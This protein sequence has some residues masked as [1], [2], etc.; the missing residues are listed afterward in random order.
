[1]IIKFV[2]S[3]LVASARRLLS[4][5]MRRLYQPLFVYHRDAKFRDLPC[6]FGQRQHHADGTALAERGRNLSCARKPRGYDWNVLIAFKRLNQSV[7][8]TVL[9]FCL[10]FWKCWCF[11]NNSEVRK[12]II[13]YGNKYAGFLIL[14]DS[15]FCLHR[16]ADSCCDLPGRPS[17][18]IS[19][20][21]SVLIKFMS[22]HLILQSCLSCVNTSR[23]TI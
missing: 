16:D 10:E 4:P 2:L 14:C 18:T 21:H 19:K 13:A 7:K 22:I 3:S 17:N 6:L 20:V 12:K 15:G 11:R 9:K 5:L 8:K 23:A 1:M